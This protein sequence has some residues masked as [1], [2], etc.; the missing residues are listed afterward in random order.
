M[1]HKLLHTLLVLGLVRVDIDGAVQRIESLGEVARRKIQLEKTGE[2]LCIFGLAIGAVV[3]FRQ[4]LEKA[5]LGLL[6]SAS[7]AMFC[8][9][10]LRRPAL[11]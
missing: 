11:R 1:A 4:I 6:F 9:N 5:M 3:E 10:S 2:Q 8:M 7:W